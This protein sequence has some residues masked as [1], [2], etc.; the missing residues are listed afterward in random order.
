MTLT[1]LVLLG[2]WVRWEHQSLRPASL[3]TGYLLLAAV[4]FL[5]L[6][7]L[8]KKL[9]QLPFGRASTWLQAHIYVGLGTL[10]IFAMHL[11]PK[12]P[13][14]RLDIALAI[15]YLLT[16]FSGLL[17]LYWT[18]TIPAQITRIGEEILHEK[19]PFFRQQV[20]RQAEQSV[21]D[22]VAAS[23]ATTLADFFS[24]R[25]ADFFER[26]RG[27]QYQLRPTSKLRRA[28]MGEM[29]NLRRY[30]TEHEQTACE[31]LF[32]LVRKKDDLDY[33][34]AKQNLLKGWLFLHIGLSALLVMLALLHGLLAHAFYGGA[35]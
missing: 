21:L 22:S 29:Q 17:G 14:G 31:K 15:V 3:T 24:T 9:P 10:A 25:L 2:G 20:A 35:V 23:G 5:A 28:L 32:A 7:N 27:W 19:I 26:P 30:L 6:Y 11:G 8:R 33:L 12:L 18:R 4:L 13:T 1:F 16:F 34:E